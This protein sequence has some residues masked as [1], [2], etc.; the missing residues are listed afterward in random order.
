M[1]SVLIY[2]YLKKLISVLFEFTVG[3]VG[4]GARSKTLQITYVPKLLHL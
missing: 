2:L 4:L 3:N 1:N